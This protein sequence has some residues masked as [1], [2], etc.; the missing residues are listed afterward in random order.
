MATYL[1][2]PK[3]GMALANATV[4]EWK[5]AEGEHVDKSQPVVTIETQ[6][7][8]FDMEAEESGFVHILVQP[9]AEV[10]V[11]RVVGLIAGS[12]EELTALQQQPASEITVPT[13]GA[14]VQAAPVA[15]PGAPRA[16]PPRMDDGGHIRIS[17]VARKLAEEHMIDVTRVV[18]T[19]PEGR[20]VRE[21]IERAMAARDKGAATVGLDGRRVA[22]SVPLKGMRKAIAEH[23]QRSLSVSA[24][25]TAMG[26]IDATE[27]VKRRKEIMARPETAGTRIS[28][29]DIIVFSLA[30]ALREFPR[31]NSSLI[32]NEIKVWGSINIGVAVAL[33]DG[34]IVPVVKDADKKSLVETSQ[35]VAGLAVKAREGKLVPEE[36]TGGT[37]TLTNL[38]A[39]GAGWRFETAIINQPESAILGTG[40]IT[41]R[42]VVRDGQIVVRPM[43]TYSFTY[44]HRVIDGSLAV[45]FMAKVIEMLE[46]PTHL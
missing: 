4:V 11:G 17:P 27:L 3:L 7:T 19:G 42:A 44:D 35:A 24:Q 36:V 43:M 8:K 2:V 39:A 28:L 26:E 23:M 13:P 5:V 15:A 10:A 45:K 12:A 38:G 25:L 34:L 41:D 37:F 40:G 1:T 32:D 33:D 18:G 21:D 30:R 46:M 29:T 22:T 20:I 6:K 16:V 31:V 14:G 9:D